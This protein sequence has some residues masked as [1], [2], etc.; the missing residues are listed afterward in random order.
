MS[1]L[2]E[3]GEEGREREQR[4]SMQT[5]VEAGLGRADVELKVKTPSPVPHTEQ[6]RNPVMFTDRW[7]GGPSA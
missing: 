3:G 4:E 2:P 5:H 6:A 1:A 7:L